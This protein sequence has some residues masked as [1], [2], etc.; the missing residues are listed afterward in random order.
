MGTDGH[1]TLTSVQESDKGSYNC[2]VETDAGVTLSEKVV[3]EISGIYCHKHI[4]KIQVSLKNLL[5][6]ACF[7]DYRGN[8][9]K[10]VKGT[11]FLQMIIYRNSYRIVYDYEFITYLSYTKLSTPA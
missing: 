9:L 8:S 1:L 3:L 6:T 2:Y 7:L 5:F 10:F 4:V 11:M